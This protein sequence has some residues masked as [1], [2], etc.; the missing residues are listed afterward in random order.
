MRL[1]ALIAFLWPVFEIFGATPSP[2]ADGEGQILARE[3][4][5]IFEIKCAECHGGHLARPKGRFGYVLDLPRMAANPEMIVPGQPD[6]SDLFAL[7]DD[8]E[9]P[10]K[11]ASQ[12]PL[13]QEQ[14]DT[15]RHW[16][17]A[18]APPILSSAN[19]A[20]ALTK[21]AD[22]S[23]AQTLSFGWRLI[24]ALGQFHPPS[25]H[26]PITLLIL[27]LP[28]EALWR[29]SGQ[30]SW[31]AVVRF[32]LTLGATC[33][34]LT[35]TLG[36]CDAAFSNYTASSAPILLWHR[37]LGTCTAAWAVLTAVLSEWAHRRREKRWLQ[38]AFLFVLCIGLL[39]VTAAG[40][41]GASLLYG[42]H[43]FQW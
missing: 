34:V 7:V 2:V 21:K 19:L 38:H 35:A 24:R 26:F 10:G 28:A 4:S 30:R 8:E 20:S 3:V 43:H 23:G 12:P 37:W 36:W 39:L 5:A 31:K 33:A 11:K 16:I 27:A 9:M 41:L 17:E 14:K 15:V 6:R 22:A 18:G 13:T 32:C 42:L 25:S 40:Y 29:R 1:A